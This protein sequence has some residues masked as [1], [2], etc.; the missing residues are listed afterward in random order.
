MKYVY[1]GLFVA[2][3][4]FAFE[5]LLLGACGSLTLGQ[6]LWDV[7]GGFLVAFVG[8]AGLHDLKERKEEE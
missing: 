6:A 4:V 8:V 2:G 5:V 7:L 3:V 1:K